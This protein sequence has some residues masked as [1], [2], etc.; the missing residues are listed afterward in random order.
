MST[1]PRSATPSPKPD[2]ESTIQLLDGL[3]TFE[4]FVDARAVARHLKL[5]CRQV[6]ALTRAGKLPA[7]PIDPT[8]TRKQWRYKLSEVDA[9][10]S[11]SGKLSTDSGIA[12]NA[13]RQDNSARQPR[14]QKAG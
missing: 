2:L 5:E 7:H 3:V 13:A 1:Q 4:S 14:Y 12:P 9:A 10:I 11:S 6:L 8:A